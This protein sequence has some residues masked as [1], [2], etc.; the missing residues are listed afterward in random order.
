MP[1]VA[2]HHCGVSGW[3]LQTFACFYLYHGFN[4]CSAMAPGAQSRG[5]YAVQRDQQ[6]SVL[7]PVSTSAGHS[8][9]LFGLVPDQGSGWLGLTSHQVPL[10]VFGAVR[11]WQEQDGGQPQMEGSVVSFFT[12]Y[13]AA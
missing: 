9:R 13:R 12:G 3:V 10:V 7:M 6:L 1:C 5:M 4:L 11:C 8:L 2:V